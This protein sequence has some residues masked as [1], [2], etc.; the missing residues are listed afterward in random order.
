MGPI[1][2]DAKEA[3]NILLGRERDAVSPW[4]DHAISEASLEEGIQDIQMAVEEGLQ[5]IEEGKNM[6]S[7]EE[8]DEDSHKE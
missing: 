5:E 6:D 4:D 3:L 8:S 2:D 1:H 7:D